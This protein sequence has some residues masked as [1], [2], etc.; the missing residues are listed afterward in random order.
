MVK[1]RLL[2]ILVFVVLPP[3]VVFLA[4]RWHVNADAA[5]NGGVNQGLMIW[6]VVGGV[7][8]L[9]WSALAAW[10]IERRIL[11]DREFRSLRWE[12]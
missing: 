4:G 1:T 3:V 5:Q 9:C 8:A 12:R 7:V 10:V 6:W 11:G 2:L